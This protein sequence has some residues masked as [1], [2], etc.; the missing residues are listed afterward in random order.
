MPEKEEIRYQCSPICI[1]IFTNVV[2]YSFTSLIYKYMRNIGGEMSFPVLV[3]ITMLSDGRVCPGGE[4]LEY[5]E[6]L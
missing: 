1:Y 3:T 4:Y 6:P 2:K 5:N